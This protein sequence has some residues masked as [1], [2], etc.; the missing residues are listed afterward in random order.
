VKYIVELEK[1]KLWVGDMEWP[2]IY[3]S[4][5]TEEEAKK[6]DTKN[7]AESVRDWVNNEDDYPH[8]RIVEVEEVEG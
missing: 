5:I 6:F 7:E 4:T 3:S 2:F 1:E 8:A